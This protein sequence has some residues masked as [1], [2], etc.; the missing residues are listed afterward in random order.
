MSVSWI[1]AAGNDAGFIGWVGEVGRV[2][3][4]AIVFVVTKAVT[5]LV[6]DAAVAAEGVRHD[7][8][9]GV[10]RASVGVGGHDRIGTGGN[11]VDGTRLGDGVVGGTVDACQC[12]G[13][14]GARRDGEGGRAVCCRQG[15]GGQVHLDAAQHQGVLTGIDQRG[16]AAVVGGGGGIVLSVG[17]VGAA[18]H[19]DGEGGGEV[20]A[21]IAVV[22]L[23]AAASRVAVVT[24]GLPV[25]LE[26]VVAR[27][28]GAEQV[29]A[30]SRGVPLLVAG[31]GQLGIVG[32]REGGEGARGV[33][34]GV[35][36]V[37]EGAAAN[38]GPAVLV[39]LQLPAV[40]GE[41][42][43]GSEVAEVGAGKDA[44]PVG[45]EAA[46]KVLVSGSAV[47]NHIGLENVPSCMALKGKQKAGCERQEY[48]GTHGVSLVW[49]MVKYSTPP[50]QGHQPGVECSESVVLY[51]REDRNL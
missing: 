9:Q 20:G 8:H 32:Q 40:E 18:G 22:F 29:D 46:G 13:R 51:Y 19:D 4:E 27:G 26:H 48:R 39:G 17:R 6:A 5:V 36:P 47:E 15:G 24:I 42:I 35:D 3:V 44:G 7:E 14:R 45:V 2:A 21:A 37:V 12:E 38:V 28:E 31:V 49:L 33:A 30:G 50:S 16:A 34:R 25:E 10:A 11:A 43:G 41:G 23:L 1:H